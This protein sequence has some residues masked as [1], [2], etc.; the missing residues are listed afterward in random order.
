[1]IKELILVVLSDRD[2]SVAGNTVE[3]GGL[4]NREMKEEKRFE[5]INRKRK[6]RRKKRRRG[7]AVVVVVVV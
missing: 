3:G 2:R 1:M 4:E 6:E 7:T 5:R